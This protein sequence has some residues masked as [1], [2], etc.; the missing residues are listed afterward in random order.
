MHLEQPE[1]HVLAGAVPHTNTIGQK[2]K[3]ILLLCVRICSIITTFVL[4]NPTGR[5]LKSD[6]EIYSAF[7]FPLLQSSQTF[8]IIT[9]QYY[10][11][12]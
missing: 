3:E 6:R 10:F 8:L 11:F 5:S 9:L 7:L 12:S 1:S 4:E 2:K